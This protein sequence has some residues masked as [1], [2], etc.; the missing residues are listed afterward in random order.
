MKDAAVR[1]RYLLLLLLP[2]WCGL[3]RSEDGDVA[4]P[5]G[6]AGAE[7]VCVTQ[8]G[9]VVGTRT[10]SEVEAGE[11]G[12]RTIPRLILQKVELGPAPAAVPSL[13]ITEILGLDVLNWRAISCKDK[14]FIAAT[15]LT[16]TCAFEHPDN[17][18]G[19]MWLI[20]VS[21]DSA[22]PD[23]RL[24]TFDELQQLFC[25]MRSRSKETWPGSHTH[26]FGTAADIVL[27]APDLCVAL[28]RGTLEKPDYKPKDVVWARPFSTDPLK[29]SDGGGRVL[30]GKFTRIAATRAGKDLV[31]AVCTPDS[32]LAIFLAP[33]EGEADK[34][35]Q[36]QVAD[37]E[38]EDKSIVT[39]LAAATF[40][41]E[42]VLLVCTWSKRQGGSSRLAF[43]T[44]DGQTRHWRV[45]RARS[46]EGSVRSAS[47][48]SVGGDLAYAY[49]LRTNKG[50]Q[51]LRIGKLTAGE[52][53]MG[54]LKDEPKGP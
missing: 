32:G 15:D 20:P 36:E 48:G 38:H 51:G 30:T 39:D 17:V 12:S 28:T 1:L 26:F 10:R 27:V 29:W 35:S 14:V 52:L 5:L 16:G 44:R 7:R 37:A 50:N 41:G 8:S 6:D 13:G 49:L 3:S 46:V 22:P 9:I 31:L 25:A 2:V 40:N 33:L 23:M 42:P 47:I 24:S 18:T 54:D 4:V 21:F 53:G 19:R 43:Y 11:K 34:A 45:Q